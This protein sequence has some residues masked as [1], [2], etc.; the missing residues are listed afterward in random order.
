MTRALQ[1]LLRRPL[2]VAST[3]VVL[4]VAVL[5]GWADKTYFGPRPS[6][7]ADVRHVPLLAGWLPRP[8]AT[9]AGV[10]P[11]AYLI[12]VH[13]RRA[14][15]VD[16]ID[17]AVG[18]AEVAY[19]QREGVLDSLAGTGGRF[20][21][22][23]VGAN[24]DAVVWVSLPPASVQDRS[25]AVKVYAGARPVPMTAYFPFQ[26]DALALI[27]HLSQILIGLFAIEALAITAV[28]HLVRWLSKPS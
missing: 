26:D 19:R 24:E 23:S 20:R 27:L 13:N 9:M 8:A 22:G 1:F 16:S 5:I 7:S 25:R 21:V 15:V 14:V 2:L 18:D 28:F 4:S 6:L 12:R 3:C 10:Q 17:V 11:A